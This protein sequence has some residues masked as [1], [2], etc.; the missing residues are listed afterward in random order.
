MRGIVFAVLLTGV[1]AST[2]QASDVTGT[3]TFEGS[4]VFS[5]PIPGIAFTDLTVAPAPTAEPT[6]N[7][8][9]CEITAVTSDSPDGAGAFPDAGTV[10][11]NITI[12][13][14]GP[15]VPDGDCILT[16]HATGSDGVA[17]SAR[18]SVT[19]FLDATEIGANTAVTG[20]GIT[21]R[22]SK[23]IAGIESACLKWVK[24]QLRLRSRCNFL[25][26]KLGP[27][28]VCRDA[29]AE[30]PA[31]CDPGNHVEAILA[32]GHGA[33]DQQTDP[34]SAEAVDFTAMRDQVVCQ[35][36][37]GR[38]A[39]AF[40][41][42][43]TKLVDKLCVDGGIDSVD[44]RSDRSRDS[45]RPLDTIDRCSTAQLVDGGTGRT[46]PVVG[47]PCDACI[48]AATLD[49]R[50]LK[51]CFQTAIDEFSD[52]IIGDVAVCGNGIDQPGEFCDDG[53]AS[54]AD[55]CSTTCTVTG[56]APGTEGPLPD[57]SCSDGI[58]ND[59]DDATDGADAG[60]Q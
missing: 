12:S 30:E 49:R 40:T 51:S 53:N 10:S 26:L 23:A 54:N 43:R 32:L 29:S 11:V 55:C 24:K 1:C 31:G 47:A 42:K 50:C 39:F 33:N 25:L 60:C 48:S 28:A 17:T 14:G 41:A 59:C 44:C 16:L 20:L 5:A 9:Q 27:S 52:G 22:E 13:R 36:L 8:E 35:R 56:N 46:V 15:Q 38:A 3:V 19:V 37:L 57:A 6:G 4:V 18:G 7:G 58:D 34:P 21:V 2:T 45:R